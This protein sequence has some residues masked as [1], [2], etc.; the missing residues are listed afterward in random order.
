MCLAFML[1]ST[2]FHYESVFGLKNK[3]ILMERFND[4]RDDLLELR[5]YEKNVFLAGDRGDVGKLTSYLLQTIN[6]FNELRDQ[7]ENIMGLR[8]FEQYQ[9]ALE[10]Y[11]KLVY[12]GIDGERTDVTDY[13]H[14]Q[15][16]EKGK[17]LN[18]YTDKLIETKRSR[19]DRAI[20]TIMFI[21][22]V[23]FVLFLAVFAF[24]L[25]KARKNISKPLSIL[26][27][28]TEKVSRGDFGQ[29]HYP[30]DRGDE[31]SACIN[32]FNKMTQEIKTRQ[33]Q[34]LHSRKMASI[35]TFTSGIAHELNNPINNIS[36]IVDTLVEGEDLSSPERLK[37]YQDLMGQ[38]DR[39]A[40]IVKGLLEFSRTD[41]EHLER[42]SLD[43]LVDKTVRLVKNK[44]HLQQIKYE[45]SVNTL[46]KPV[47]IDKSRLQQA[48][49]NL[50]INAI[51]AM[52][53]G[54][55]LTIAIRAGDNPDE[56]RI[57]VA[58]TGNGIPKEQLD[59][60]FDPF[61]TTKKEGEGTG[62]GLSVTYGIIKKHGGRITVQSTPGKGSCFSI[63]LN[64]KANHEPE[65]DSA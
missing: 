53:N 35:G 13:V 36:L 25:M 40:E 23:F 29:I 9:S 18:D 20:N 2:V 51:Q 3:L 31:I 30:V 61:F 59:S 41:Q 28:A 44:I 50:L 42:L 43:D 52:P 60:I 4:L 16:R 46:L 47:W 17:L 48:L 1:A 54:G 37:L 39:A 55:T 5:R 26:R 22:L 6:N 45:K 8:T 24:M 34:L 21:P 63:F 15:I 12:R 49:L 14:S 19:I 32:A 33:A 56:I 58:D 64:T 7:I 57:D 62:L 27:G 65:Q 11:E 38:A 10:S